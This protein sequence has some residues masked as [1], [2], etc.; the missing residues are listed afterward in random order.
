MI[1]G[2]ISIA[3]VDHMEIQEGSDW[4]D[5]DVS[6]LVCNISFSSQTISHYKETAQ[7]TQ[8]NMSSEFMTFAPN[9]PSPNSMLVISNLHQVKDCEFDH[10]SILSHLEQLEI[11]PTFCSKCSIANKYFVSP[12]PV[13]Q[14]LYKRSCHWKKIPKAS[15]T[16]DIQPYTSLEKPYYHI[17]NIEIY[18]GWMHTWTKRN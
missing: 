13:V 5:M 6:A 12:E 14:D 1:I 3:D 7:Q 10:A 15:E 2:T 4:L 18:V 16:M 11:D 8:E 9:Y 17:E